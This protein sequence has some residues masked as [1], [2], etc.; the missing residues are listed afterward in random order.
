MNLLFLL[1][2]IPT[3]LLLVYLSTLVPSD[4]L[5]LF[6]IPLLLIATGFLYLYFT[7]GRLQ[8][9]EAGPPGPGQAP[10]T[11]W[12]KLRLIHGLFYLAAFIYAFK[13]SN[14]VWVPLLMDVS[15]G[16]SVFL[17]HQFNLF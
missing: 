7:N 5:K 10:G 4:K 11:W 8:A 17:M 2:C 9:T 13:E 3:R 12:A 1:V 15:F 6:S 16:L 14:L